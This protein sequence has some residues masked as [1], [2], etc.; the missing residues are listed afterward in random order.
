MAV[1]TI[2]SLMGGTGGSVGI[3]VLA[4]F[5]TGHI[6]PKS[7]VDEIK[8]ERDEWKRTAENERL[9]ADAGVLAGQIVKDVLGSLSKKE[10]S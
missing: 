1:E 2:I 3:V 7:R 9:R 4:L 6:V 5:I 8:E 10:L